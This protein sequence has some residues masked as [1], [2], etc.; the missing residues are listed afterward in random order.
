[1]PR[2]IL[3]LRELVWSAILAVVLSAVAI[4]V[5]I[6]SPDSTTLVLGLGTSSIVS[7]LLAQ[8]VS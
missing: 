8:R 7:A 5:A 3:S 2:W 6:F 1:M 4:I